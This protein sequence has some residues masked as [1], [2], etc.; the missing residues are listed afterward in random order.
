MADSPDEQFFELLRVEP[1]YVA[2]ALALEGMLDDHIQRGKFN[3][4]RCE[5]LWRMLMDNAIH[6][7]FTNT[8]IPSRIAVPRE[9]R[10]GYAKRES[11]QFI[12]GRNNIQSQR[13]ARRG[14][15]AL[16]VGK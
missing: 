12:A 6:H 5:E 7:F 14:L 16:L 10:A 11:D 4:E 8:K 1:D 9:T 3:R 2:R 15:G 13:P